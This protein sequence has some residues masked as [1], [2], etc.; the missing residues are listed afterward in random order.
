MYGFVGTIEIGREYDVSLELHLIGRES[1]GLWAKVQHHQEPPSSMCPHVDQYLTVRL[2]PDP[3]SPP[4]VRSYSLSEL[5][6]ER[7]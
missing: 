3:E 1:I 5:P 4:L 7:G 2:R 6:G